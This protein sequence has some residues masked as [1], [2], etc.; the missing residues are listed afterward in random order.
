M[1]PN[2]NTTTPPRTSRRTVLVL[3]VMLALMA[4]L[5]APGANAREQERDRGPEPAE[6]YLVPD[7]SVVAPPPLPPAGSGAQLSRVEWVA[8][9]VETQGDG[10][11]YVLNDSNDPTF[12]SPS[13]G[14]LSPWNMVVA[15][16]PAGSDGGEF[17]VELPFPIDFYGEMYSDITVGVNGGILMGAD[18]GNLI[19]GNRSLKTNNRAGVFAFWDDL[20]FD[21]LDPLHT[22]YTCVEG[23]APHRT[24]KVIWLN[25][26]CK[27]CAADLAETVSFQ[28]AFNET[29]DAITVFYQDAIFDGGGSSRDHGAEAT[30]GIDSGSGGY[31]QYSRNQATIGGGPF[32]VRF[33]VATCQGSAATLVGT[34]AG[35]TLRGTD[36]S[37]VI[38]AWGGDDTVRSRGGKDTVCGNGGD[39]LIITGDGGDTVLGHTGD[40]TIKTGAGNDRAYGGPGDDTILGG[41]GDDELNGEGQNDIVKGQ[42]GDDVL[43]GG[44][45]DD[46]VRGGGGDDTVFGD[47]GVD[48]CI[49]NSGHDLGQAISCETKEGIELFVVF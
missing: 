31:L 42:G 49:G 38:V 13:F 28:V 39:D 25:V 29:V 26:D 27:G 14:C 7:N 30:I 4:A 40:D 41:S 36:E 9:A 35:E 15:H 33:S 8:P 11:N 16:D 1:S 12:M 2:R 47:A 37:D 24:F 20:E 23:E 19:K 18:A 22:I 10:N 3:A 32:W 17:N 5:L 44:S 45:D 34:R 48:I 6:E 46:E 43:S 21:A